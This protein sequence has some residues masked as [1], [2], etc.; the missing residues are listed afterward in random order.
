MDH[1]YVDVLVHLNYIFMIEV[2]VISLGFARFIFY[3]IAF[4][5]ASLVA[6][7]NGN[8]FVMTFLLGISALDYCFMIGLLLFR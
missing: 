7:M 4:L 8:E 5:L 3:V 6:L 1:Y 2:Y